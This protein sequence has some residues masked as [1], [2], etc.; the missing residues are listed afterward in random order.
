MTPDEV[1]AAVVEGAIV[2]DLRAPRPFAREHLPGALTMQFNRAD[3]A[4]RAELMLPRDVPLVVH[5]E[6][7]PIARV[8]VELLAGAGF[9]VAGALDGGLAAWKASG[10]QTAALPLL[11]VDELHAQLDAVEVL[12]VREPFEFRHGHVPGSQ[13]LPS[14]EAWGRLDEVPADRP[15]AV[16]CGDQTRSAAVASM[17][18][19]S[20]RD[21]RL[22]MGGMVD[23][24]ERG[25]PVE[26]EPARV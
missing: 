1:A 13:L 19:H 9:R 5:A 11:D 6:P 4:D 18:L 24:L 3:L 8:A 7:A 12:D 25:H 23:W 22:V 10:R 26:R 21:A 16:V 17:L 20:G 14:T 15:V 2:L